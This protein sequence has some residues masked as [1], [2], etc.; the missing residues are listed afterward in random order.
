[1]DHV[2]AEML[3]IKSPLKELRVELQHK[4]IFWCDNIGEAAIAS[5]LVYML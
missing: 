1:M 5:D 4:L 2:T 3:W